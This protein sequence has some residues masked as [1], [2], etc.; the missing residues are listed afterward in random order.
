[1]KKQSELMI[2]MRKRHS[3]RIFSDSEV[4]PAIIEQILDM[5]RYVPSSCNR[6]AIK[7]KIVA[8]RND[9]ELLGGLL[10]G[11]VGWIHR[12]NKIV[13]LFADSKA[14]KEKL[15]F[16]PYLDA[17]AVLMAVYM[18]CAERGL[19]CCYVNPNV[20]EE[21]RFCFDRRFVEHEDQIFCG[22]LAIGFKD[23]EP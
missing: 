3:S 20:R 7:I 23:K 19:G 5:I 2:L 14:Y 4:P 17:G 22:A 11:G 15:E 8:N 12:S 10:V 1:M 18:Y 13:M 6:Q 9:K 16:M 21:N